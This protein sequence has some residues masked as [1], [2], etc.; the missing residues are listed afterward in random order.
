[1]ARFE[2][3]DNREAY[4][5]LHWLELSFRR[6]YHEPPSAPGIREGKRLHGLQQVNCLLR[7][8][9]FVIVELGKVEAHLCQNVRDRCARE[10]AYPIFCDA[11]LIKQRLIKLIQMRDTGYLFPN[12]AFLF[13]HAN[14]FRFRQHVEAASISF[15]A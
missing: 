12:R 7:V 11:L 14:G 5:P 1:M 9:E 10:T 15:R 6:S 3:D 2:I 13:C 8:V 4:C